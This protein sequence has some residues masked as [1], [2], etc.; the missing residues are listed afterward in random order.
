MPR[1][2]D[3]AVAVTRLLEEAQG[4]LSADE[5]RQALAETGIGIATVYRLLKRGVEDGR[6]IPIEIPNGPTH[7]EPAD[8][9]HH[10]HFEC[11]TCHRVYDVMG[12]PGHLDELTPEGFSL[13]S[14]DVLLRGH[15][16]TCSETPTP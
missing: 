1:P 12:C 14:H 2:S 10:H 8:R 3:H 4:P 13:E 5:V 15:C 7:Y 9:P 6:Y 11:L 16:V